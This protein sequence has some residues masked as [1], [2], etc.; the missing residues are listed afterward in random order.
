MK[1]ATLLLLLIL[2]SCCIFAQR[3]PKIKGNRSVVEVR[4][5]LPAFK[6]IELNDDLDIVLQKSSEE[7]Y[8][9]VAD[10][11]LLD[12]FKFD[13]VDSILIISSF[14][15]ITAKKK[16]EITVNYKELEAITLREGRVT[17]ESM[18]SSDKFY[19]N[20]LGISKLKLSINAGLVNITMEGN[21]S[22]D[23][24]VD[25]DSLYVSLHDKINATIYSV[26][27]TASI[28]MFKNASVEM[29][30]TTD[31]LQVKLAD[32]TTF[33]GTTLE[34]ANAYINLEG[35]STARVYAYKNFELTS[36]GN[37]KTFLSGNPKITITK[38]LNTSILRKEED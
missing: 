18:I 30:G 23:F 8:T 3:K 29:E 16:L 31:S 33:K 21:S 34:A 12:I 24:N 6:K 32:N 7:S 19:V 14:Y 37:S 2:S 11:N 38:F 35:S 1:R 15:K 28:E 13:V 4:E 36:S 17:G 9:L 22:G 27:E 10:D 20:S 5:Y 26:A 25:S